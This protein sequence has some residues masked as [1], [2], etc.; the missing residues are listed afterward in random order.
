MT[1][2][3]FIQAEAD[4]TD[5]IILYKEGLFWKA[6]EQS[7]YI[8]CMQVRPFKPI[9]KC[10]KSL[11]GGEIV[12]IG[13]PCKNETKYIGGLQQ[14]ES[15][16]NRL[17]LAASTP[18][19]PADFKEW[20]ARVPLYQPLPAGKSE[21]KAGH[22]EAMLPQWEENVQEIGTEHPTA[23][24]SPE[25]ERAD[26]HDELQRVLGGTVDFTLSTACAVAQ[27]IRLFNLAEHTPMECM[28]FISELQKTLQLP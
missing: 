20:K 28:F 11:D 7:A 8:T 27:R 18:I 14:I 9:K 12:S 15:S 26:T 23:C 6:Y 19:V 1:S 24:P 25:K 4:N 13:F 5:R 10:L 3:D 17:V 16:D 21:N 2:R 22:T